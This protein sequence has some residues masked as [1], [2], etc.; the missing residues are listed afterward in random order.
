MP[1]SKW[2]YERNVLTVVGSK[3]TTYSRRETLECGG[4]ER[5][6]IRKV[7]VTFSNNSF[8]VSKKLLGRF[9]EERGH[10]RKDGTEGVLS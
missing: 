1:Q 5:R 9:S 3:T 7:N 4:T 2:G 8:R 6:A 10:K